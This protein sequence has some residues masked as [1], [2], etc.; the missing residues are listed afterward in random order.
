MVSTDSLIVAGSVFGQCYG[1]S[2]TGER[3]WKRKILDDCILHLSPLLALNSEYFFFASSTRDVAFHSTKSRKTVRELVSTYANIH[4]MDASANGC[5][6]GTSDSA[7]VLSADGEVAVMKAISVT[8]ILDLSPSGFMVGTDGGDLYRTDN[9]GVTK[10]FAKAHYSAI[11]Y[12]ASGNEGALVRILSTGCGSD[13]IA[14]VWTDN[15]DQLWTVGDRSPVV[16]AVVATSKQFVAAVT[17]EGAITFHR[18]DGS[19]LRCIRTA[20]V[21]ED[22]VLRVCNSMA[23]LGKPGGLCRVWKL[24]MKDSAERKVTAA[25]NHGSPSP[26]RITRHVVNSTV[27]VDV[28]PRR[29]SQLTHGND[30]V[31]KR[32]DFDAFMSA[33]AFEVAIFQFA[34]TKFIAR[35]SQTLDIDFSSLDLGMITPLLAECIMHAKHRLVVGMPEEAI[36]DEAELFAA[37][38]RNSILFQGSIMAAGVHRFVMVREVS[39]TPTFRGLCFYW[40]PAELKPSLTIGSVVS[41]PTVIVAAITF[42]EL[43]LQPLC[44]MGGILAVI[45]SRSARVMSPTDDRVVF[46][47]FTTFQVGDPDDAAETVGPTK[48][49]NSRTTFWM[50][51]E[52]HVAC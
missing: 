10:R 9:S 28:S 13:C 23:C 37:S 30:V 17:Q 44:D 49:V 33:N 18:W 14:A 6:V 12:L 4:A 21:G 38:I 22:E 2:W 26:M 43:F 39:S 35:K 27:V 16:S 36:I 40:F 19:L 50:L 5:L 45:Q 15:C 52:Y 24:T 1:F 51:Y 32:S 7:Y 20:P 48:T 41:F 8:A 31:E 46:S 34:V 29:S 11:T 47:P 25:E 3:L 42:Q